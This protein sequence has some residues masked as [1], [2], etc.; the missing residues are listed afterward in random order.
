VSVYERSKW[1]NNRAGRS[2]DLGA[3]VS[4]PASQLLIG[5]RAF[6]TGAT[7][8]IGRAICVRFKEQGASV[9]PT[10]SNPDPSATACDVTDESAVAAAFEECAS[11]GPITDVVHA[12]GAL[13]VGS[14]SEEPLERVRRLLDVNLMGSFIVARAAAKYL[15]EGGALTLISSQAGLKSG[16]LWASYSAGKA[17]VLRLVEALAQEIGPRGIR[18]NAVCP[19][20][21]ETP[22]LLDVFRSVGGITGHAAEEVRERYISAIPL[23]RFARPEEVAD[24]CVFLSSSLASYV[25]GTHLLVDGGELSG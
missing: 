3:R 24:V 18:V 12:A 23:G 9:F 4:N 11:G 25:S 7:G 1:S 2:A 19:G 5:R 8:G 6:V 22:M 17:G 15:A 13:G 21:V 14:V 10:D 20:C 16:N